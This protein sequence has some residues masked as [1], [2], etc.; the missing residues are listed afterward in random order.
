V[1]TSLVN[2][3]KAMGG[4]WVIAAQRD[5]DET[6]RPDTQPDPETQPASPE[7][8]DPDNTGTNPAATS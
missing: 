8:T 5:A 4:G 7:Q 1:Y 2:T 6:D 3:Y